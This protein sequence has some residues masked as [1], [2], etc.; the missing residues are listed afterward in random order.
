MNI[1]DFNL[2]NRAEA[3]LCTMLGAN[4][5]PHALIF[6]GGKAE[7]RL[8][9]AKK[10][11][12]V[13]LCENESERPCGVC[14]HCKKVAHD[15]H[16]DVFYIDPRK[17]DKTILLRVDQIRE[18]RQ[19]C[20]SSPNE[21]AEKVFVLK[22]TQLMNLQAQNAFLKILEEPPQYVSFILLC[23]NKSG[24]LDTILSRAPVLTLGEPQVDYTNPELLEPL[25]AALEMARAVS[26]DSAFEVV[27]AAGIFEKNK[28]LFED[29]LPIL[30]QIIA[31]ARRC[32]YDAPMQG[33]P[34]FCGVPA[35]MAD[36]L[37][38][39]KMQKCFD[40]VQRAIDELSKN[41]NLNLTQVRLCAGLG[42]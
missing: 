3:L 17:K 6:E 29:A 39:S 33:E 9:L 23:D 16:P 1:N 7:E 41:A 19:Y 15:S 42:L 25:T 26:K 21:G 27:K 32:K 35:E 22:D 30:L 20:A 36:A 13:I 12:K 34:S 4:R 40:S 11:A 28:K 31:E 14:S 10:T 24:F 5:L 18:I 8:A 38:A 2:N 37:S